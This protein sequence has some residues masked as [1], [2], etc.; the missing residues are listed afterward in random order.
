MIYIKVN[1]Q[2]ISTLESHFRSE[3]A[4]FDYKNQSLQNINTLEVRQN[5]ARNP[6]SP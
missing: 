6:Q 1:L 3:V 4:F 5:I 2:K